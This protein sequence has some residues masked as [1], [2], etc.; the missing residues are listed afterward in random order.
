[1]NT[2]IDLNGKWEGIITLGKEYGKHQGQEIV[3]ESEIFYSENKF[4]GFSFDVKGFG[5]NPEPADINGKLD[6]IKISF[7]KQ[8]RVRHSLTN[9]EKIRIDQ[10]RKGPKIHYEGIF[11]VTSNSFEGKWTMFVARKFFGLIPL[12]IKTTGNWNMKRKI[13]V[14]N[15]V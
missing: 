6:G 7:I 5:L 9:S 2:E 12:N 8:Y 13:T 11:N 4:S 14:A 1:M 10:N 3:Y 15:N